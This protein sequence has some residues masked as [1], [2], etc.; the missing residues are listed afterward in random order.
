M[1]NSPHFVAVFIAGATCAMSALGAPTAHAASDG[2]VQITLAEAIE[3][4]LA[5]AIE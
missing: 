1:T 5:E 4:A 3:I 2:P